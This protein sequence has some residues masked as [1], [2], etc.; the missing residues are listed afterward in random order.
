MDLQGFEQFL[1]VHKGF[2]QITIEGYQSCASRF[3]KRVR[4]LTITQ[5]AHTTNLRPAM[6]K[7][8]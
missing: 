7:C 2:Q 6:Y 3:I 1:L 4:I 5:Q 8:V